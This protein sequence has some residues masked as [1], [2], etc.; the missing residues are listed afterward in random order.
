MDSKDN[1]F[2]LNNLRFYP[3][4]PNKNQIINNDIPFSTINYSTNYTKNI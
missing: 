1:I 3:Y 4:T 2:T